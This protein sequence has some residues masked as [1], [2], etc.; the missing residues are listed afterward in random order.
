MDVA[1]D[2]GGCEIGGGDADGCKVLVVLVRGRV[3]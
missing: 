3:T 1:A 2:G